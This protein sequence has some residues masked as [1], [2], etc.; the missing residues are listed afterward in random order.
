ML[1][2][3]S[4]KVAETMLINRTWKATWRAISIQELPAA[5]LAAN[6]DP[7]SEP[8]VVSEISFSCEIFRDRPQICFSCV[9]AV[10]GVET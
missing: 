9:Q 3:T 6:R 10:S 1:L 8:Q 7:A 2:R 5:L 4:L